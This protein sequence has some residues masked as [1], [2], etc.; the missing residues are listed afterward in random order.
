MDGPVIRMG[1]WLGGTLAMEMVC[2]SMAS[3]MATRSSSLI[4]A[5]KKSLA[6]V[7]QPGK[8]SDGQKKKRIQ[9]CQTRR[10]KP[11]RRRPAPWLRPPW[12]SRGCWGLAALRP[13]DRLHC[14]PYQRCTPEDPPPRVNQKE[15]QTGQACREKLR[16][17]T[18]SN[19]FFTFCVIILTK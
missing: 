16:H 17:A 19:N 1:V 15:T 10:C 11:L 5:T 8:C 4:W 2:C 9:P 6:V 12:W 13:S 14:Y 7:L 18:T 3:W